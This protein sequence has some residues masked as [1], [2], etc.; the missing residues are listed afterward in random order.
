MSKRQTYSADLK[1]KIMERLSSGESVALLSC[2][3]GVPESTLRGWAHSRK[4]AE[5]LLQPEEYCRLQKEEFVKGAWRVISTGLCLL[6][7]R[8]L[9]AL[10]KE[11]QFDALTD[12]ILCC[13]ELSA[14]ERKAALR[15]LAALRLED[16]NKIKSVVSSLYDKQSSACG[17]EQPEESHGFE[18]FDDEE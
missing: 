4:E 9:R 6:E 11:E 13:D 16:I 7:R 10:Q 15:E 12:Q 1:N 2:Q 14:E 5:D 3:T 18:D 8:M 17:S